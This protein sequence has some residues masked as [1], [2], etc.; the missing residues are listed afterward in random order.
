MTSFL[1]P[2]F[3]WFWQCSLRTLLSFLPR[4]LLSSIQITDW[5]LP[6]LQ[7]TPS[8]ST[9]PSLASTYP[10]P[11][12][13]QLALQSTSGL[14]RPLLNCPFCCLVGWSQL[15]SELVKVCLRWDR[16][17]AQ[18]RLLF[19][20]RM[21]HGWGLC[22]R[23]PSALFVCI[24]RLWPPLLSSSTSTNQQGSSSCSSLSCQ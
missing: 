17:T 1:F 18:A 15:G 8:S 11:S 14:P 16:V 13:L 5:I 4:A 7:T 12:C 2:F 21:L 20:F 3:R 19:R 23:K 6:L 24:A 22:C 9:S 10:L